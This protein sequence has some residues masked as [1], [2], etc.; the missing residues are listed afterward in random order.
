MQGWLCCN[1]VLNLESSSFISG[2]LSHIDSEM[3]LVNVKEFSKA[4][5]ALELVEYQ[6]LVS[7]HIDAARECLKSQWF[8]AIQNIFLLVSELVSSSQMTE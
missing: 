7:R 1:T 8:M 5:V 2:D 3:Q 6:A 4:G